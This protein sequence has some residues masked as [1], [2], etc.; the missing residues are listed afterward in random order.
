[1]QALAASEAG[2]LHLVEVSPDAIFLI[3]DGRAS[4]VNPA[5]TALL[6]VAPERVIGSPAG[7]SSP[8]ASGTTWRLASPERRG[9]VAE[10]ALSARD[11]QVEATFLAVGDDAAPPAR[12]G[13]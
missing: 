7:T 4:Y 2:Y 8:P 10:L 9:G 6:R 3:E 12:A 5:A 11:V 1:M 13:W